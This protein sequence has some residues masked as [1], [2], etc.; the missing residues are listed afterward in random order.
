MSGWAAF[1]ASGRRARPQPFT[2]AGESP[3]NKSRT[4]H[5]YTMHAVE[6]TV[7]ALL[8]LLLVQVA[9]LSADR[10]GDQAMQQGECENLQVPAGSKLAFKVYADGDQI[11]SWNG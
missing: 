8:T 10:I 2:S 3:L 11:Y 5:P 4:A 9:P 6:R 7:A 1:S